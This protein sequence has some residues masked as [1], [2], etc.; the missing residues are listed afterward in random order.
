MSVMRNK[1][2]MY[3]EDVRYDSYH[4]YQRQKVK[5]GKIIMKYTTLAS[6]DH[7]SLD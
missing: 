6:M 4:I 5:I 3:L 1:N 7:R 2:K